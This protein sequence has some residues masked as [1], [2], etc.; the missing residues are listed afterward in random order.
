MQAFMSKLEIEAMELETLFK[1]LSDD[2]HQTVD[3]ETFVVGCMKIRGPARSMDLVGLI[4]M[5]HKKGRKVEKLLSQTMGR[6]KKGREAI[7]SDHGTH[8][9]CGAQD[10][11]SDEILGREKA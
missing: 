3:L 10:A 5:E 9:E 4:E 11:R 7:E 1:L 8:E 2:G 6:M